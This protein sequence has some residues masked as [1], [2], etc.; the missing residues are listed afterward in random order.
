MTDRTNNTYSQDDDV[1]GH[2][3]GSLVVCGGPLIGVIAAIVRSEPVKQEPAG[4]QRPP[5]PRQ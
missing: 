5:Q 1:Q 4:N 3:Y 2:F